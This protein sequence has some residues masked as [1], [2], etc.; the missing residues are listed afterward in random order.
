MKFGTIRKMLAPLALILALA[1]ACTSGLGETD[2]IRLIQEHS[3]PGPV[4]EQGPQGIP[5]PQGEPGPEGLQGMQGETGPRG[6]QGEPGPTGPRGETGSQGPPGEAGPHG[7]QGEAGPPGR[8]GEAGPQGLPGAPGPQGPRGE[9]GPPGP[10]GPR[11]EPGPQGEAAEPEPDE[12]ASTPPAGSDW[13]NLKASDGDPFMVLKAQ[14]GKQTLFVACFGSRVTFWVLWDS[15]IAPADTDVIVNLG[16]DGTPPA[17]QNRTWTVNNNEIGV[18][19]PL[20]GNVEADF[21][22][23]LG[24]SST[25]II[26]I[27]EAEVK[28]ATFSVVGYSEAVTPIIKH[29]EN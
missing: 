10:Q 29:C 13:A 5:G 28:T 25:L 9:Q 15:Y 21:L 7:P 22:D 12:S 18:S 17:R 19:P 24:E 3:T 16:W 20:F 26:E 1:A 2:V 4:G 6:P 23:K 27:P 11:G 8:Q 14:D